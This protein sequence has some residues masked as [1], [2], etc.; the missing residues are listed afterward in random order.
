MLCWVSF[1]TESFY[2]RFANMAWLPSDWK[3]RSDIRTYRSLNSLYCLDWQTLCA[4]ISSAK[5]RRMSIMQSSGSGQA[6]IQI[7]KPMLAIF[8]ILLFRQRSLPVLDPLWHTLPGL[9]FLR[10][11]IPLSPDL[12]KQLLELPCPCE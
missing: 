4:G 7:F 11:P 12:R 1:F 6:S 8:D 10:L 9:S 5:I 2:F 3:F